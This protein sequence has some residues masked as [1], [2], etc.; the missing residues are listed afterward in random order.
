M[1][2]DDFNRMKELFISAG[3]DL[4]QKQLDRFSR[5]YD[6]LVSSN[7]DRDLSRLTARDDIFI[8]HFIDS[9]YIT[10][11]CELSFPLLDIGTG[12]G[13]PGIPLKILHPG[14]EVI[15]AEHRHRRVSFLGRVISDLELP[16]TE[17]YPHLVTEKSFFS[18]Q[19]VI[20]RALE[21]IDETLARVSHFLPVSG[22]VFFLK[23]PSAEEDLNLLSEKNLSAYKIEKD[24]PYTLPGTSYNRRL[25]I[26]RKT[27][28]S[29]ARTF[30]IPRENTGAE[31]RTISSRENTHFKEFR[32]AAESGKKSGTTII[33]GKKIITDYLA[34]AG[35][36]LL[37]GNMLLL[38]DG[39]TEKDDSFLRI[40]ESF[41]DKGNLFILK[42]SL[43]KEVDL[44]Q[45]DAPL[46]LI[47]RPELSQWSGALNPG[48]TL[49]LPF[50][51][52]VNIGSVIR[53]AAGLGVRDIIILEG[54]ADPFHPRVIRT[55]AGAVFIVS[56]YRGPSARSLY[57]SCK[58]NNIPVLTLDA[59]GTDINSC[60]FPDRFILIPGVEGPGLPD[61]LKASALSIPLDQGVESLNGAVSASIAL[62]EWKR[63]KTV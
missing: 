17:V 16:N 9:L 18:V 49:A 32:R 28:G 38:F 54:A 56:L 6:L 10:S 45:S 23:G 24:I 41:K 46:L 5:Y 30:Y 42:K 15:L 2:S 7:Q 12:A 61:E 63:K 55:S 29:R 59:K 27:G 50:Q 40:M 14:A 8:K 36:N 22:K 44:L 33:T 43:F 35:D 21:T 52:P 26:A 51:D 11:L 47:P 4:D 58:E 53:S 62:Y 1:K 37:Q 19:G 39:Y 57:H 34:S 13:F 25:V 3:L 20:T 48:C 31:G 60:V